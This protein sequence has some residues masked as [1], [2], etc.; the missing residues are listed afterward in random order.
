[1]TNRISGSAPE[2]DD[3]SDPGK[4]SFGEEMRKNAGSSRPSTQGGEP[5]PGKLSPE[6]YLESLIRELRD[7]VAAEGGG[8]APDISRTKFVQLALD[9]LSPGEADDLYILM[10]KYPELGREFERILEE[11]ASAQN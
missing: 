7:R 2:P 4:A 5:A 8:E 1:M 6:D 11:L 10:F 3:P 9:Q